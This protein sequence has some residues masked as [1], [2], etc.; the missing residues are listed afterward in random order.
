[1]ARMFED[2]LTLENVSRPQLV[3]MCQFMKLN[4]YGTDSFLRFQV[5]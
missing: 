4:P 5:I 3:G 1:M 2:E